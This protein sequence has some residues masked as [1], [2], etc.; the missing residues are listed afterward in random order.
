M[1]IFQLVGLCACCTSQQLIAETDTHARTNSLALKEHTDML[2]RLPA[3]FRVTR[4]VG[5]EKAVKLQLVE[6]I[7]P[8]DSH[9]LN[10]TSHQATDYIG[11]H[12]AV[13]QNYT[14]GSRVTGISRWMIDGDLLTAHLLYPIHAS[15][16]FDI[17]CSQRNS[18][19]LIPHSTFL[20]PHPTFH[21]P[22]STNLYPPHHHAMLSEHLGQSSGVDTRDGGY[23]LAL[24][25]R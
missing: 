7:V 2:N 19:F 11:L 20:I 15:V 23:L 21:I 16:F 22:H 18:T 14:F 17:R 1:T 3:L 8:R 24:K 6:V 13:Y 25:P 12:T 4:S 5:E 10:T 9:Y